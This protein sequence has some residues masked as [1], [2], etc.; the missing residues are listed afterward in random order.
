VTSTTHTDAVRVAVTVEVSAERAFQL[1][2]KQFDQI[3]PREHNLLA[4]EPI[5]QTC[6]GPGSAACLRPRRER[7]GVSLGSGCSPSSHRTAS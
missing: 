4:P 6:S 3:K 1:F 2:T 5:A 7:V